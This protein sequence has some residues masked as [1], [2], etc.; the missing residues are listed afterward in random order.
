VLTRRDANRIKN[1]ITRDR[2]EINEKYTRQYFVRDILYWMLTSNFD[3]A[4]WLDREDDRRIHIA[5]LKQQVPLAKRFGADC[6]ARAKAW[7]QSREGAAAIN[8]FFLHYPCAGFDPKAPS[9]VTEGQKI[10]HEMGLSTLDKFVRDLTEDP[11]RLAGELHSDFVRLDE[12]RKAFLNEYPDIQTIS[13]QA[14]GS[15]ISQFGGCYIARKLQWRTAEGKQHEARVW[16]LRNAQYWEAATKDQRVAHYLNPEHNPGPKT[17][18][19][20]GN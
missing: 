12:I 14:I 5:R 20:Q 11:S 6:G 16:A 8:W 1:A 15:A 7:A 3:D 4:V 17:T 9:P 13:D 10:A 19:M 2:V 18:S